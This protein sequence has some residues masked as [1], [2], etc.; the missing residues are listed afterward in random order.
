MW[1]NKQKTADMVT[2]TE[3]VLNGKLQVLCGG[4]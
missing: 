2:V 3:E 4:H 1:P